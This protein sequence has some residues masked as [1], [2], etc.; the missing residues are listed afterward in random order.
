M[1]MREQILL[2]FSQIA[3]KLPAITED[4]C[5]IG[6]SAM[7]LSELP[8]THTADIDILTTQAGA[9]QWKCVLKDYR[10]HA[11]LTK[12]DDLF[13]S[14]F[15]RFNLPAMDIEVMGGLQVNKAGVWH[16]VQVKDYNVLSFETFNIR[17]PTLTDQKRILTLFGREKDRHRLSFFPL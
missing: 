2:T 9:E 1:N 3:D 6:A 15:A 4:W 14:D 12:E 8:V 10:E 13:R 5:V 17:I 7:I 11:P 16:N